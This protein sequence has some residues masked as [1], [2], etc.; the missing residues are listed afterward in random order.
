[1]TEVTTILFLQIGRK[2]YEVADLEQASRMFCA[3]RD[4]SGLGMSRISEPLITDEHGTVV[5]YV[6]YN[7]RV[8]AGAPQD[9]NVDSKPIYDNR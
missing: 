8:W 2:R 1:M 5:A 7:G 6:S 9:W 4:K 3:A